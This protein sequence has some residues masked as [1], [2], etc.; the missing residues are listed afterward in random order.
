[1]TL[2]EVAYMILEAARNNNIVD[3]EDID[4]RLVYDWIDLKREQ[5]ITNRLR[6]NP[7]SRIS[8]N[9]Y[10]NQPVT[11][12]V[13]AATDSGDYPYYTADI[14]PASILRSTAVI[15]SIIENK[16]GPLVYS[17]ESNNQVQFPYSIVD[18]DHLRFAGN[19]K[20]N[21]NVIFAA[22]RDSYVY[23]KYNSIL[24]TYTTVIVR[25]IFEKP[26]EV[27]GYNISTDRYP[28][29]LDLVEYI[30]NG[31][32]DKDFKVIM[33]TKSDEINDSSGEINNK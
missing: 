12:E 5:Y 31:I 32:F 27:T 13:I 1:M 30:K 3:D 9:L 19:G 23:F 24:E 18:Y 17:I 10:Q 28:A 20:F 26:R 15:P 11:L 8:L 22:L 33:A 4:L 29:D 2:T 6:Q 21:G 25:A 16:S 14:Q 7:N